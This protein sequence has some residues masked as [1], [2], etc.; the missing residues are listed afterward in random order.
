MGAK[1]TGNSQHRVVLHHP[2]M[3]KSVV[4]IAWRMDVPVIDLF[5]RS[6][7]DTDHFHIEMQCLTCHLVVAV[8]HYLVAFHRLDSNLLMAILTLSRENHPRFNVLDAAEHGAIDCVHQI[9]I[10]LSIG[11][12]GRNDGAELL[13][14]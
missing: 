14:C 4:M 8:D 2:A 10:T 7:T 3:R 13:S 9:R 11:E 6:F 12:L 1:S 5:F